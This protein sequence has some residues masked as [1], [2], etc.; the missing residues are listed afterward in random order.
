ME[1]VAMNGKIQLL[2]A[3]KGE[4]IR[5]VQTIRSCLAFMI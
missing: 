5:F 3:P 1:T 4:L 2:I